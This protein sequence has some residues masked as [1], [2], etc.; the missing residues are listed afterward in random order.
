MSEQAIVVASTLTPVLVDLMAP[1]I[2]KN[3]P[4]GG[5][6]STVA[7]CINEAVKQK[8]QPISLNASTILADFMKGV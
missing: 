6:S 8:V 5:V 2:N 3:Q 7:V 4:D 1:C